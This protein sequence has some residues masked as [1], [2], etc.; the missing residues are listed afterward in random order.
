MSLGGFTNFAK[1]ALLT[2]QKHIDSA[3]H[4]EEEEEE[5]DEEEEQNEEDVE[6]EEVS[7][8]DGVV[9][10]SIY[11]VENHEADE[12]VSGGDALLHPSAVGDSSFLEVDLNRTLTPHSQWT[13]DSTGTMHPIVDTEPNPIRDA[14]EPNHIFHYSPSSHSPDDDES[15]QNGQ[16]SSSQSAFVSSALDVSLTNLYKEKENDECDDERSMP[17]RASERTLDRFEDVRTIASSDIEVIRQMDDWSVTSSY[18]N[19]SHQQS[20]TQKIGQIQ[21][22]GELQQSQ[23]PPELTTKL[24]T[25]EQS[26]REMDEKIAILMAKLA[27]RDQKIEEL[28]RANENLRTTNATLVAKSKQKNAAEAKL[29]SQFAEKEKQLIDLLDEGRKLSEY[30]GRQAKEIRKFKQQLEQLDIVTAARDSAVEELQEAHQQLQ[31]QENAMEHLKDELENCEQKAKKLQAQL[32]D[33]ITNGTNLEGKVCEQLTKVEALTAEKRRMEKTLQTTS[34]EREE[35]AQENKKLAA[36]LM[37]RKAQDRIIGERERGL[38]EELRQERLKSESA[39]ARIR[40]LEQR[41][42]CIQDMNRDIAVEISNANS[43]L[44]F[45]ISSLEEKL[46]GLEREND[47]LTRSTRQ[48]SAE[49]GAMKRRHEAEMETIERNLEEEKQQ[50]AQKTEE[51]AKAFSERANIQSRVEK[52]EDELSQSKR[53]HSERVKRMEKR[54][55]QLE[56]DIQAKRNEL[57]ELQRKNCEFQQKIIASTMERRNN[58]NS[59]LIVNPLDQQQKRIDTEDE[60]GGQNERVRGG[61]QGKQTTEEWRKVPIAVPLQRFGNASTTSSQMRLDTLQGEHSPTNSYSLD[62]GSVEHLRTELNSA[63]SNLFQLH[64][65]FENLLEMYGGCLETIE[66]VKYD[67]EDLRKLC[68]EQALKLAEFQSVCPPS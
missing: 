57:T 60:M 41:I 1:N 38:E 59:L 10:K 43:P 50:N 16:S 65:R 66:E 42:E 12:M 47:I 36:K 32:D 6:K 8:S 63:H 55:E 54:M 68:K 29:Q 17:R 37:N 34:R 4:I 35:L 21:S 56:T 5:D 52:L 40:E 61:Q 46:L 22:I 51:L 19:S 9:M 58:A 2:A 3:L 30:S 45:T 23:T 48:M 33:K 13:N 62:T 53:E 7:I 28:G 27:H 49:L 14:H 39:N 64:E 11:A 67:N 31:E 18:P 25:S 15:S 26:Q 44:L 20:N 24:N